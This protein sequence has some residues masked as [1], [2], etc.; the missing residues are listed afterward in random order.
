MFSFAAQAAHGQ[1]TL[2]AP[3]LVEVATVVTVLGRKSAPPPLIE[4][5]DVNVYEGQVHKDVLYWFPARGERADL[6]LAIV[7]DDADIKIGNQLEQLR[8]FI[9]AQPKTTSIGLYYASNAAIQTASQLNPD[10]R[11]VAKS[12]RLPIGT[13]G[14]F[15]SVYQAL[16]LLMSGWPSTGA[17][18]EILLISEGF[19]AF[20]SGMNSPA[21]DAATDAAQS[22]GII[23]YPLFVNAVGRFAPFASSG[24]NYLSQLAGATGGD[25]LFLGMD[26]PQSFEP[27]LSQLSTILQNQYFLVWRTT[28]PRTKKGQLRS[29]K[30]RLEETNVRL[31]AADKIFVPALP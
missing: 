1:Q 23:I 9:L 8:K 15:S 22:R 13:V 27:Y 20:N 24:L 28:P 4:Q 31:T 7:I 25:L 26:T 21:A 18:R 29:F 5:E 16:S 11:P 14:N 3:G 12:L 6:Q 30:V 17:R 2:A 10:H 19:D